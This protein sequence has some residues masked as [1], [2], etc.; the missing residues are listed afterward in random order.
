MIPGGLGAMC[1][2]YRLRRSLSEPSGRALVS[3][4]CCKIRGIGYACHRMPAITKNLKSASARRD[5]RAGC[6]LCVAC[7]HA[8]LPCD[9]GSGTVPNRLQGNHRISI[10]ATELN[11]C[12]L[13]ASR[14]CHQP[15]PTN[16][17]RSRPLD[18]YSQLND[19][20]GWPMRHCPDVFASTRVQGI[21]KILPTTIRAMPAART[22]PRG[23][24]D[25]R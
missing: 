16:L 14:W 13:L 12:G 24:R 9:I 18:A 3:D 15:R 4:G 10:N 23:S 20:F 21:C 2:T 1:S 17:Y 8:E 19:V 11:I 25:A 5:S 7:G 22:R 6:I